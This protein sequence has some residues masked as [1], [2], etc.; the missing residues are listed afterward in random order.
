MSATFD[1]L[2]LPGFDDREPEVQPAPARQP[3]NPA[4]LQTATFAG[5]PVATIVL[6]AI[7]L[8]LALLSAWQ[9]REILALRSHRMVSVSLATLVRDYI[10]SEAKNTGSPEVT[11]LRTKLYLAATQSAIH[12][13]TASGTTVL[14]SEAVA[15]DSVPD[16]TNSIKGAI[17]DKL[18]ATQIAAMSG[19][20]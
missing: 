12:D 4:G 10:G 6:G 11:A 13:L 17:Q 1:P 16:V 8:L 5:L 9:T 3:V 20:S 2:V 19:R 15:G 7:V 18:K 14:V